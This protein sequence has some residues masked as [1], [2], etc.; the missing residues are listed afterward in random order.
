MA[1]LA[2]HLSGLDMAQLVRGR[3]SR[4]HDAA[5]QGLTRKACRPKLR[6]LCCCASIDSSDES[7]DVAVIGAGPAGLTAALALRR[8]V[9]ALRVAVFDQA[10]DFR[11]AGV[12]FRGGDEA[13]RGISRRSVCHT[14]PIIIATITGRLSDQPGR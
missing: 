8:A 12:Y 7:Y 14:T 4:V 3:G 1:I 9:P 2:A 13:R 6:M 5:R 11:P 10:R